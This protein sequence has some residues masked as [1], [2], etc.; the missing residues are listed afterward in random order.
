MMHPSKHQSPGLIAR[1][2]LLAVAVASC[3][4]AAPVL[5]AGTLP[6]GATNLVGIQAQNIVYGNN[7]LTITT[8][9]ARSA[10]DWARFSICAGNAASR[11]TKPAVLGVTSGVAEL[12][13]IAAGCQ[14]EA[15]RR[16][17]AKRQRRVEAV[18]SDPDERQRTA[19]GIGDHDGA[20]VARPGSRRV[21]GGG[22][23]HRQNAHR[24]AGSRKRVHRHQAE[25]P[26]SDPHLA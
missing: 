2:R 20:N 26:G 12:Q 24:H 15:Q 21:A 13:C 23:Q 7:S 6:A 3:F 4:A 16:G 17:A 1:Q 14:G 18:A 19:G 10:A 9:A 5:G 11:N 22:E 25:R 8:S